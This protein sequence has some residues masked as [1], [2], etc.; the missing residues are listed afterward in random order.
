[1]DGLLV[2]WEK[3]WMVFYLYGKR[4]GWSTIYMGKGMDG[5]LFMDPAVSN[6]C[7]VNSESVSIFVWNN[8]FTNSSLSLGCLSPLSMHVPTTG[9]PIGGIKHNLL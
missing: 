6:N 7:S 8:H 9:W 5:L 3:V 4:Y 2:I 1:M